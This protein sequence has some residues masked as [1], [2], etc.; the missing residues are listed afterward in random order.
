VALPTVAVSSRETPTSSRRVRLEG[1]SDRLTTVEASL[2][3]LQR[4]I[5]E[6]E[7][8]EMEIGEQEPD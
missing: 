1:V 5:A 7:I 6:M 2:A 4:R 3:D 8:G